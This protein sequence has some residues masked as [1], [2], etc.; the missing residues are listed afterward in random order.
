VIS[1]TGKQRTSRFSRM[2]ADVHA[3]VLRPRRAHRRLAHN[4][5]SGVAFR[6]YNDVGTLMLLI[7][8]LHSPAYTHPC[9]R[10]A[11]ALADT[12]V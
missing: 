10:S 9:Q 6:A 4:A 12:G 11:A 3:L 7:S 2:K 1:R 8:R 5:A